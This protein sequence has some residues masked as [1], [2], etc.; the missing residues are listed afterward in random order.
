MSFKIGDEVRH[1]VYPSW[2]TGYVYDIRTKD[3][4]PVCV[5]WEDDN[6]S[7]SYTQDGYRGSSVPY[8]R[9]VTKLDK[10]LK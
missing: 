10:A 7:T 9:K 6:N 4:R 8:I 3:K 1:C 5:R 2:G